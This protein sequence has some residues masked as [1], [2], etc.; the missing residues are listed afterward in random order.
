MDKERVMSESASFPLNAWYA[1]GWRRDFDATLTART[2]CDIPMVFFRRRD[3]GVSALEDVCQHRLLPLSMGRLDNDRVIC[4]YHGMTFS[5]SG[6]CLKV[7]GAPGVTPSKAN[8]VRTFPTVERHGLVWVWPGD[9]SEAN[10][11]EIPDLHWADDPAWSYAPCYLH[12]ACDFRLVLDNLMDLTHESYVHLS[13][14]GQSELTE[15]P[16]E[17]TVDGKHVWLK[18]LML[19]MIAP[20]FLAAQ[21]KLA[22]GLPPEHVDRWQII[23]F[24]APSTIVIDVGVAPHNTGATKGDYSQGV[25]T[26]VINAVTPGLAGEAHYFFALARNFLIEDAALTEN[27]GSRNVKIFLEDKAILEGQYQN[28]TRLPE[29]KLLN[30]GI[31]KGVVRARRAIAQ[32]VARESDSLPVQYDDEHVA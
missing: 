31:D 2:I 16:F 10:G 18:R 22:R 24:E 17:V 25:N 30:F 7:P 11:T 19:D 20:P 27:M 28:M 6:E 4:G 1:A 8:G 32:L 21:L 5:A 26:Q 9:P 23:H 29:R 3:G 13:S 12:M 15:A 14:I